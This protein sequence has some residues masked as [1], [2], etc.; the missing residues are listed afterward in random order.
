MLLFLDHNSKIVREFNYF[1]FVLFF[2]IIKKS[3]GVFSDE[4]TLDLYM[5]WYRLQVAG[6]LKFVTVISR[7]D[8][9]KHLKL[10]F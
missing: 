6:K 8:V 4:F 9:D 2:H 3:W 7:V 1:L 10:R 5:D